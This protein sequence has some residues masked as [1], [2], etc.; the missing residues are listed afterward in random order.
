[1]AAAD[2]FLNFF[3]TGDA[4]QLSE[5]MK[6]LSSLICTFLLTAMMAVNSFASYGSM[7]F[8][9]FSKDGRYLA[10]ENTDSGGDAG[11]G[12]LTTYFIDTAK[13][14]YAMSPIVLKDDDDNKPAKYKAASRLYEQR[15]AAG[16]KKFGIVRGNTGSIVV[17]HLLSDW[18]CVNPS[19]SKRDFHAAD[20]TTKEMM[21]TDYKGAIVRRDK[22]SVEKVIFNPSFDSYLQNTYEF[23]E[24]TLTATPVQGQKEEESANFRMELTLQDKTKHKFIEP[25]FLQKDGPAL[26]KDRS[27]AYGYKIESIYVYNNKIAVFINVFG[28][29]FEETDMNYMVVTGELD[30]D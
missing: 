3:E 6:K 7:D 2:L 27:F 17:S 30:Q 26:P 11:G 28:Q 23:Y 29:G 12:S 21:M 24:L 16:I 10:F 8:I 13:N 5:T 22:S 9:G 25:R 14:S 20:G 4:S 1:M 15:L 18:S 19:E